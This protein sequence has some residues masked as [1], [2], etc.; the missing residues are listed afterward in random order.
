VLLAGALLVRPAIVPLANAKTIAAA[1][2]TFLS[3]LLLALR[4]ALASETHE[5][6]TDGASA[7]A[8]ILMGLGIGAFVRSLLRR[9]LLLAAGARLCENHFADADVSDDLLTVLSVADTPDGLS[10]GEAAKAGEASRLFETMN[11][12]NPDEEME[13]LLLGDGRTAAGEIFSD[14]NPSEDKP[15]AATDGDDTTSSCL[16]ELL[17][18][19]P[20]AAPPPP[21]AETP[22]QAQQ[23]AQARRAQERNARSQS[24][25]I[26][27]L[28]SLLGISDRRR[29]HPAPARAANEAEQTLA[30]TQRPP[31][32]VGSTADGTLE[33]A[34]FMLS[35]L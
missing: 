4:S 32:R 20:S 18:V 21:P 8:V 14:S 11:L 5:V 1:A 30:R 25:D 16:N 24:V 34:I 15:N 3:S 31:R 28:R 10:S 22:P 6:M 17:S 29:H 13:I 27:A 7:C 33:A 2:M 23:G 35:D 12:D 26:G 9:G 19:D